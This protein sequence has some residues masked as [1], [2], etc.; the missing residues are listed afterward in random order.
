MT[1]SDGRPPSKPQTTQL[2]PLPIDVISIQS[3]VVYG[4]VG[5]S[6]ATPTLQRLGLRVAAL[7]TAVL[8]NTPHYPTMHGGA[9]SD[10]WFAAYLADLE[11][12]NALASARAI[13]IGYLANP[14][15]A[16]SLSAWLDRVCARHPQLRVY[17][18]PVIG[19]FDHDVYTAPGMIQA[20][21]ELLPRAH[22]L[23][24][25][26]FEL[27]RLVDRP[28][29]SL[30]D[31]FSAAADLLQSEADWIIITSAAPDSWPTGEMRVA[32]VTP[33]ERQVFT[34]PH[35]PSLVK[36]AGDLFGALL[37]GRLLAGDAL[38][39]AINH[40]CQDVVASLQSTSQAGWEELVPSL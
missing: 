7:P 35:I 18:D 29:P 9:L 2:R 24:P 16:N 30:E 4:S 22:G 39:T 32:L 31:C 3:Q 8:S 21:R 27:E 23:L 14:A 36:G 6:I 26:H 12:R 20:W 34:H 38:L 28:L 19:D 15:Q 11:E 37:I 13:L 33:S 25:N 1:T 17:V 10:A 40:S 5:N